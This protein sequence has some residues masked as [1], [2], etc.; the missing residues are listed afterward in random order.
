MFLQRTLGNASSRPVKRTREISATQFAQR[1][2]KDGTGRQRNQDAKETEQLAKRQQRKNHRE[3]MQADTLAD[4]P[5]G[6]NNAPEKQLKIRGFSGRL[7]GRGDLEAQR[8]RAT[9]ERGDA[10]FALLLLVAL[11]PLVD[12]GFAA[13]EHEVHHARELVGDRG[14]GARLVHARAQPAV[15][16]TERRVAA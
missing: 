15:E 9:P 4:K 8:G 10:A 5:G 16:R 2:S 12:E 3:W 1:Q 7:A 6:K 11:L 13:R 14:I